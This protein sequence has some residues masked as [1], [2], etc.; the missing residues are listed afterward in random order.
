MSS[1]RA[2]SFVRRHRAP[3]AVAAVALATL[4]GWLL[5]GAYMDP[6]ETRSAREVAPWSERASFT[7]AVPVTRN[8]THWPVGTILPMGEPAYFRTISDAILV[9]FDWDAEGEASGV[10]A[11][12]LVVEVRATARDGRTLWVVERPLDSSAVERVAEGITLSGRMDLD[13]LV[14]EVKRIGLELPMTDGRINWTVR[15]TVLYALDVTGLHQSGESV[16]L[17][18]V[19][20]AD[21]RFVLPTAD[22]LRWEDRHAERVESVRSHPAGW[23]GV[24]G[25]LRAQALVVAGAALGGLLSWAGPRRTEDEDLPPE[26]ARYR[27]W[28]TVARRVPDPERHGMIVDVSTLQDLVHVANDARTRVVM[29][30]GTRTYYAFLPGATYRFAG[31]R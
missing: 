20:V 17:L 2:R 27:D 8:S 30:A 19:D 3:L 9:D 6:V 1:T 18:P 29:D 25:A 16:Y 26:H 31:W 22:A 13:A 23:S 21:P 14:E 24:A 28:V 15:A 7:Y 4:G 5:L 12:D 10:A 11:A